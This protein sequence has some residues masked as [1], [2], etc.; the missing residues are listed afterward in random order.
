MPAMSQSWT[1]ADAV[2]WITPPREDD[3]KY[4][5]GVL[6]FAT[7]SLRYPGAAVIGVD[8]AIHTGVG[9]VRYAGPEAVARLVLQRRPEAIPEA[10]RAQAWVVG[11]G[12]ETGPDRAFAPTDG[13]A[14]VVDAGAIGTTPT[15]LAPTILTPHAGELARLLGTTREEVLGDPTGAARQ[16]STD[17]GAVVLLKGATTLVVLGDRV[18]AVRA[19]TPWLATAGA[20]DALA[21][22]LGALVATRAARGHIDL[23]ALLGLG[24]TAAYLHGSAA[25]LAAGAAPDGSGGGPFTILDLN[26]AL[27]EAI[28]EILS[29]AR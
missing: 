25:R 28:R 29:R 1:A 3:D 16:A 4:A 2:P 6:G 15:D 17:L 11:S 22:V 26:A 23:D 5:R 19:A 10:G 8:A 21:G 14:F 13:M 7:G 20:G 24:A 18:V 9:M 27:P 12:T